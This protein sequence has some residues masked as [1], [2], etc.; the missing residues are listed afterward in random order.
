[1]PAPMM[2]TPSG[3][4]KTLSDVHDAHLPKPTDMIMM[5]PLGRMCPVDLTAGAA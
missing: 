1:M 2:T 4:A 3:P 5:E